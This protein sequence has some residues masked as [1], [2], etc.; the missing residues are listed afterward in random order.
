MSADSLERELKG[1]EIVVD[2]KLRISFRHTI[3]V[4]DN[5]RISK[6]PPDLGA[7]PI[8]A[9]ADYRNKMEPAIAAKGGVFFPIYQSE[10][11]WI[12]F[13]CEPN[14]KYMIKIYVG[15]V[16]AIS[17]EPAIEDAGTKLR[18][19]ARMAE[20][21]GKGSECI[22]LQDYIIVPGQ[23]WLDGIADYRTMIGQSIRIHVESS[24]TI[25]MLMLW[26][27]DHLDYPSNQQRLIFRKTGL[28]NEGYCPLTQMAIAAGRKIEQGIV[29]DRL[30]DRWERKCTTVFNAQILNSA[31]MDAKIYKQLGLPFY[32][33]YEEPS[34]ISGDFSL[35]KS[36]AQINGETEEVITPDT[37]EI[38]NMATQQLVGL[39]NP[40][41]PLREFRTLR[42]LVK[43][44]ERLHVASF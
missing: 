1:S 24:D 33:L 17:G 16:N 39:T 11:I 36:V 12:D 37:V 26:I 21:N 30:R 14:S 29:P 25:E 13:S 8:K 35:F 32:K 27:Q 3:R 6:L 18:L 41:G 42:D 7:Y 20:V 23:M 28:K 2:D 9:V 38:N 40:N 19:Q 44:F 5:E 15:S 22:P 31:P 10:A 43:E 34:G 4:P